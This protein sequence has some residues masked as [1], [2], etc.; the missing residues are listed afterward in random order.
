[1]GFFLF[2]SQHFASD[3]VGWKMLILGFTKGTQQFRL[4][5]L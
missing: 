4:L 2:N 1:L 5:S 3:K